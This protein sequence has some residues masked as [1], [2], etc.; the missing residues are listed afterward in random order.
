MTVSA[1]FSNRANSFGVMRL[2]FAM[3]VLVVHAGILGFGGHLF[4]SVDLSGIAVAGFFGVSGFLVMRSARRLPIGRYLWHRTLRIFPGLAVCLALTA[5]VLAPA[6]WL[7]DGH[8]LGAYLGGPLRDSFAHVLTNLPAAQGETS[9]HG[10]MLDT[11]YG[12]LSG[13]DV[14]NG[15]LWTLRYEVTGY[16][17]VG[18]LAVIGVIRRARIVVL[19]AA[20]G[21]FALL[22]W[23]YL[24]PLTGLGRAYLV[25]GVIGAGTPPFGLYLLMNYALWFGFTFLLGGLFDLYGDH[26]KLDDRLALLAAIVLGFFLYQGVFFGPALL[27]F[28]YLLLWLAV[29]LPAPLQKIG[30]RHDYSYGVYI[31]AFPVQQTLAKFGAQAW[32]LL[33]YL[34]LS[35][36]LTVAL[37]FASWHLIERPA[38]RAKNYQLPWPTRRPASTSAQPTS[39]LTASPSVPTQPI[40]SGATAVSPAS[41]APVPIQPASPAT[42]LGAQPMSS[43]ALTVSPAIPAT[44]PTQSASPAITPG[45]QPMSSGALVASQASPAPVPAQPD[46]PAAPAQP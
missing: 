7:A 11:P 8:P 38:L 40:P 20:A 2:V 14:F 12:K 10:L 28:A 32:G 31:Y 22:C 19:L 23:N 26:I 21:V 39:S 9:I 15:S 18:L 16:V 6:L 1:A 45:A 44:V 17:V 33:A 46:S 13:A 29:R 24:A 3:A 25:D 35:I 5:F 36:L 41:P 42:P 43:G 37:A 4:P 34:A 27:P 30:Q